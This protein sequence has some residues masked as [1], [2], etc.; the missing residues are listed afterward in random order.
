MAGV[1]DFFDTPHFIGVVLPGYLSI[2]AF[3]GLFR[4][5]ILLGMAAVPSDTFS[6]VLFLVAGP[7]VGLTIQ[8]LHR[9]IHGIW[10]FDI[11][12]RLH[13][14]K[15]VNRETYYKQHSRMKLSMKD[16]ERA[17]LSIY[18]ANYDFLASI[19]LVFFMLG[20]FFMLV[21]RIV[22]VVDFGLVISGLVILSCG[23]FQRQYVE[24]M[25]N[26]LI[27]KYRARQPE[28]RSRR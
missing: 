16:S 23:Y 1:L 5:E 2:I 28:R 8:Q 21:K 14:A 25:R 17:E 7:A 9:A 6:A 19:G 3:L 26:N 10:R 18:E 11:K 4:P 20:L 27:K 12:W 22:G 13:L 24:I 15:R